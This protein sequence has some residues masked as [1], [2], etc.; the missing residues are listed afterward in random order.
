MRIIIKNK[1]ISVLKSWVFISSIILLMCSIF[2]GYYL[3]LIVFEPDNTIEEKR[4]AVP[5]KMG[6]LE[7]KIT[8]SGTI[9]FPSFEILEFKVNGIAGAVNVEEGDV[10]QKGDIIAELSDSTIVDLKAAVVQAEKKL[11]D[12]VE[13]LNELLAPPSELDVKIAESDLAKA[14]LDEKQAIDTLEVYLE[15]S[16]ELEIESAKN[17]LIKAKSQKDSAKEILYKNQNP[18]TGLNTLESDAI[19]DVS[20]AENNLLHEQY[21][22]KNIESDEVDKVSQIQKDYDESLLKYSDLLKGYFGSNLN[23]KYLKLSPAEIESEWGVKFSEIFK[24]NRVNPIYGSFMNQDETPWDESIVFAWV[25]LYPTVILTQCETSS[26]YTKCPES[27]ISDQWE[28]VDSQLDLLNQAEENKIITVKKQEDKVSSLQEIY[29][30]ALEEL[31]KTRSEISL[32]E[33]ISNLKLAE[34]EVKDAEEKLSDLFETPDGIIVADLEAKIDLAKANIRDAANTLE[35]LY[36]KNEDE[37]SLARSEI[38]QAQAVLNDALYDLGHTRIV[39][40]NSGKITLISI[41]EGDSVQRGQQIVTLLDENYAIVTA[42]FDEIDIMSLN[43]GDEV[44][45]S[46]DSMPNQN[47]WGELVEIGDGVSNQG[48]TKFPVEVEIEQ[49]GTFKLIEGLSA[50]LSISTLMVRNVLM[51]PNQAILGTFM[52]PMV[53]VFIDDENFESLSV[54]LG[55]SDEFWVVIESGLQLEDKVMMKS[56][57]ETDP[58]EILMR[59]IPRNFG[60]GFGP[61][62]GGRPPGGGR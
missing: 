39:A 45:I 23:E 16:T 48:I 31:D 50:N 58:F 47:L 38:D 52:N 7:Q 18:E 10:V 3:G 57:S 8:A 41:E 30:N 44:L 27:E 53:D 51:V 13:H 49:P 54:T 62:P 59:G 42:N 32:E 24:T 35:E 37:I 14:R 61:P 40:P 22:L 2:A 11:N 5:V 6:D 33:K 34:V 36:K 9:T 20:I 60:S 56:V 28:L 17:N 19:E 46:L 43:I 12:T 15:P 4:V 55:P 21:I 25:N 26:K 1:I 29:N